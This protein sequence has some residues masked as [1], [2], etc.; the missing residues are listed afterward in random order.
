MTIA[1]SLSQGI[2]VIAGDIGN[3]STIVED[4]KNGLLFKYDNKDQLKEKVLQIENDD[5]LLKVISN[6]ATNSF[7][8]KYTEDINYK[9]L[10]NIYSKCSRRS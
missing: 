1:E 3:L 6:G 4:R 2:P 9:L 5:K 7:N 8:E 10:V